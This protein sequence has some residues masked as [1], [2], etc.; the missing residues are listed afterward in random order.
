M[1]ELPEVETIR[2]QLAPRL[3]GRRIEHVEVLDA[4]WSEPAAPD[5]VADAIE[6]RQIL[7][8]GRRG[9]YFDFA[10]EGEVHL[11]MHLRM[12]GNLLLVPAASRDEQRYVRMWFALDDG[13]SVLFA[14]PRRFGTGLVLLGDDAR[15]EYF[16]T[17]L[18][19]EPLSPD[20]TPQAL[21]ALAKGR[22]SPVKAFL[23]AQE[24]IAGVGNIYADEALFRAR[25]HPLRPVGTLR[26]PQVEALHGA[27]VESLE[28]GIDAR[29]AS[30]DDFRHV[31]G[32][33][34]SFQDRFLVHRREGEPCPRC[35]TAIVKL[36]AAGRGT[37][38]CPR[39][40]RPPRA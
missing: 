16:S 28:A 24:R 18:G 26:R 38:V 30:I 6:G 21:H 39:C 31:D 23:L 1:P 3:E 25:I 20:F 17:R 15:D 40:Q 19:V 22:R 35:G 27:V 32:A 33:R 14:D 10:L 4:R 2:R 12:T 5:E 8:L 11:V 29:G 13:S 36:R 37:Y 9:K 34:G 7:T